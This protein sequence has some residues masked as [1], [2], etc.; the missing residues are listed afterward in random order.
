MIKSV[1]VWVFT[2]SISAWLQLLNTLLYKITLRE[3]I[4]LTLLLIEWE[5]EVLFKVLD[6]ALKFVLLFKER[7][8]SLY[9]HNLALHLAR[10][11]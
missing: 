7:T 8:I 2:D 5:Y 1:I 11:T 6:P 4:T 3:E 10:E 9:I